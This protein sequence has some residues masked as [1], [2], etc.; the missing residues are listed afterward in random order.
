MFSCF[1]KHWIWLHGISLFLFEFLRTERHSF[2][3]IWIFKNRKCF[4]DAVEISLINFILKYNSF[5]YI[6]SLAYFCVLM[7]NQLKPCARS[8]NISPVSYVLLLFHAPKEAWYKKSI[9]NRKIW[10]ARK[11]FFILQSTHISMCTCSTCFKLGITISFGITFVIRPQ[12]VDTLFIVRR[13]HALI[14]P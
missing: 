1:H 9:V 7:R 8:T 6:A 14:Q 11:I 4:L 3:F 5:I 13:A 10:G 2:L 12:F